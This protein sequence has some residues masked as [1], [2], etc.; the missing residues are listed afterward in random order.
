MSLKNITEDIED[1]A[2]HKKKSD[3]ENL[4][5]NMNN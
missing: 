2:C 5:Q 3:M 4:I 1:D